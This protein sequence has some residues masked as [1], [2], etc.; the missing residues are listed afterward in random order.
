MSFILRN[1]IHNS[2]VDTVYS[3]FVSRRANYYYYI[4]KPTEWVD[5][6]S[7]E[8]P[9][10]TGSYEYQ[11]RNNIV[12]VKRINTRDISFVVPRRDWVINTIYD[13]Y[14]PNYSTNNPS[15]TGATSLKSSLFYVLTSTFGVYKCIS[16]N[17]GAPS[18]IEPSGSDVIPVQYNDGYI[19]KYLYTIPLSSRNRFL[20]EQYM[21]VQVSVSEAFYSNGGI[22]EVVIDNPGQGYS[23]LSNV[24]LNVVG[25]FVGRPGNANALIV[26]VIN[27][28]GQF[29]DVQIRN[30]G[31][32]YS[33]A[34]IIISDLPG[35]GTSLHSGV[36]N[37]RIYNV[38]TGYTTAVRNNTRVNISTSGNVQPSSNAVLQPVYS[39]FNNNLVSVNVLNSG[40]GYSA[41]VR[42]NTIV[43]ITTTG[44][45]LPASNATANL[46]FNTS[47]VIT[48]V[49][50][51]GKIEN[52]SIIDPGL[53]YI[54]N[55]RTTI[56]VNGDGVGALLIPVINDQGEISD[57]VIE[58]QG[59]GYT[60]ASIN[61]NGTGSNANAYAVLSS[62][63]L[64]T[65][66]SIIELSAVDG[67]IHTCKVNDGGINYTSANIAVYGDGTGFIGNVV[68]F[69]NTITGIEV[70]NPGVNYTYANVVITGTGSNANVSAIISPPG[71]H[72]KNAVKELFADTIMFYSTINE[73]RN[74]GIKV[75]NDY[76]Q[77]GI[78]KDIK[79]FNTDQAYT[80]ASGS[81][82]ML[83]T[84]NSVQGLAPDTTLI[85]VDSNN[86]NRTFDVVDVISDTNQVLLLNKTNYNLEA[87]DYLRNDS[88]AEYLV[89]QVNKTP[90]INKFSGELLF[91]DNRTAVSSSDRQVVTLRTIL[92]L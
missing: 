65:L 76:R 23:N 77:F 37:V 57:I 18:T 33:N 7:P 51:N 43:Q 4:G 79:K 56:T 62:G 49:I 68:L 14:D 8:L 42:N 60:F 1:T 78:I 71:G 36:S 58:N 55:S 92:Q 5:S 82:C 16:N 70:I 32:N 13:Q 3:E 30:P 81:A 2:L 88:L 61:I 22:S 40:S 72:G 85:F 45:F 90:D 89:V 73:E 27:S 47:A 66:Q 91:I 9:E 19:W 86:Q 67:A 25:T 34:S 31:N 87:D 63:D 6:A 50:G 26:P 52:I 15:T 83:V 64:N 84:L 12:S 53:N 38:G 20:T 41:A 28:L 10:T 29:V 44:A 21:P 39:G 54:G 24:T 46:F 69:G 74:H 48:P 75:V 11:T 17:R 80:L 59:E 35:T